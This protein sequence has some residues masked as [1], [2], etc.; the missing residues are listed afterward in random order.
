M[1]IWQKSDSTFVGS[2]T[3][4]K[5]IKLLIKSK[6]F[7]SLASIGIVLIYMNSLREE[8]RIIM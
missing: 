7:L 3:A 2:N 4:L 1:S 6:G 8:L 5:S